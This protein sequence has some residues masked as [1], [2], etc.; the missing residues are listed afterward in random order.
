MKIRRALISVSNKTGLVGF[1]RRLVKHDVEILSTGGT[2]SELRNHDIEIRDVSNYTKFPEIMNGRVKTLHPLIHGG[3]L[4]IRKNEKHLNDAKNNSI[5][6]IDLVIINLYP[7]EETIK[8]D[9]S[10]NECIE[11]IDI[12]GPAMI[13]SAAKNH[14]F[15]TVIT[16]PNDY[17]KLLDEMESNSSGTTLNFRKSMAIKAFKKTTEYDKNI[18]RWLS[19]FTDNKVDEEYFPLNLDLNLKRK[20]ILR[21]GENPHQKAAIYFDEPEQNSIFSSKQL[22]GKPLSYNNINDTEAAVEI[23]NELE[24]FDLPT[25][26]IIK[27]ANPC[28]I[29]IN[30]S[31]KK[32]YENALKC[33]PISAFGGIIATNRKIDKSIAEKLAKIFTEVI[34]APEY[35]D[36]ALTIL[37]KNQNLRIL[38]NKN[39]VKLVYGKHLIKS[40]SGG[41]LVQDRDTTSVSRNNLEVVTNLNPNVEQTNDLLFA[42]K[43]AKHVKSNAIVY[44]K[45]LATV[46]I[47]A[48]QMS[49]LDSAF[50]AA[51]KSDIAAKEAKLSEKLTNNSVAASDAFFPFPDGL[52][53]VVKAG[54]KAV[55][56]PGGSIKDKDVIK[57]A[58]KLKIAMVFCG[59]R[60]FKH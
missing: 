19:G 50:I 33:D 60:H 36:E 24:F 21:Y 39:L 25:V 6:F 23:I 13:R 7:F 31:L 29:A 22:H 16:D 48:G 18:Y 8:R 56:Q 58:N 44:A 41:Y 12:G 53:T 32:A 20:S 55:I 45:N 38:E 11:N 59:I 47:G 46:G 54:A 35:E 40:I 17:N 30:K 42:F 27:H 51:H 5:E 10:Y 37:Q 43:V 52:E 9:N 49:R 26:V 4:A 34:I 2:A 1:V 57:A 15:I 3:I 28:G 14:E